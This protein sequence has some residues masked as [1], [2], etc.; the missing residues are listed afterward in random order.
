MDRFKKVFAEKY[1]NKQINKQTNKQQLTT[2]TILDY[3]RLESIFH[4]LEADTLYSYKFNNKNLKYLDNKSYR[5]LNRIYKYVVEKCNGN[6]E[7]FL[8]PILK[9]LITT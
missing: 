7:E 3:N 8:K 6:F 5:I 9:Y 1:T 4:V 2:Y